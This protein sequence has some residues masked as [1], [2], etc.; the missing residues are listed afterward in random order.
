MGGG[1]AQ[2]C[3][4][5]PTRPCLPPPPGSVPGHSGRVA[6]GLLL[7]PSADPEAPPFSVSPRTLEF[8][9]VPWPG[10]GRGRGLTG[11]WVGSQ[12]MGRRTD[13]ERDRTGA[14]GFLGARAWLRGWPPLPRSPPPSPSPV[15][16][17]VEGAAP[18]SL[19]AL[20]T[21]INIRWWGSP[22]RAAEEAEPSAHPLPLP[23]L[24]GVRVEAR[25]SWGLWVGQLWR[26]GWGCVMGV[27]D[28][29]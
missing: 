23:S 13:L 3:V 22:P 24:L 29:G 17:E 11:G 19:A 16:A 20:I 1:L 25:T 28:G 21:V 5:A 12:Q 9:A 18:R 4:P 2:E 26:A 7:S 8:L 14:H 15:L 27:G 6:G 10:R